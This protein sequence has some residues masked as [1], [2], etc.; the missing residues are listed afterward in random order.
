MQYSLNF[1]IFLFS[2]FQA[3][4]VVT[5]RLV[6]V[7]SSTIYIYFLGSPNDEFRREYSSAVSLVISQ[8]PEHQ[9][10]CQLA[11]KRYNFMR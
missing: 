6:E 11:L 9:L 2:D 4:S 1:L 5:F 3:T 10:H 8:V 7:F